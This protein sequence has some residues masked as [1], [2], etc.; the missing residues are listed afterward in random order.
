[1]ALY[2]KQY[3]SLNNSLSKNILV[4]LRKKDTKFAAALYVFGEKDGLSFTLEQFKALLS[5]KKNVLSYMDGGAQAIEFDLPSVETDLNGSGRKAQCAML[6][7]R[8][9]EKASGKV[10]VVCLAKKTF[11]RLVELSDLIIHAMTKLENSAVE[12]EKVFTSEHQNAAL[13]VNE[14]GLDLHALGM[15]LNLFQQGVK[16]CIF[17]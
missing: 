12:C 17:K 14:H 13:G 8:Q 10:S 2:L 11:E 15:E 5:E 7:L 1:M 4:C 9:V 16:D 6:L 3:F